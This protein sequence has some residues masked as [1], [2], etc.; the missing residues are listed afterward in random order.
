MM[1]STLMW[2]LAFTLS[3][4]SA[5]AKQFVVP[6]TAWPAPIYR[7]SALAARAFVD[8]GVWPV[9]SGELPSNIIA[10]G[11][12]RDVAAAMLR[13]SPTFR[14]QC[15]RIGAASLTVTV[16]NMAASGSRPY[17]AS[18]R[19]HR[20]GDGLLLADVHIRPGGNREELL[21]H[22]FEHIIEQLDGVDLAALARR[23]GTG[24]H[25]VPNAPEFETDRAV[26]V[27]RQVAREVRAVRGT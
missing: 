26:I 23:H 5:T 27:G 20:R 24:V 4:A 6:H 1:R 8:D 10:P 7:T 21:A 12:L 2:S 22:E 17:V 25:V 9:R 15:A 11:V 19:I 13:A 18:T 16:D 3:A 14:R